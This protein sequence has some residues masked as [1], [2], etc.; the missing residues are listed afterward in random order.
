MSLRNLLFA[1]I[2]ALSL[3]LVVV[4]GK[5]ALDAWK[6][7]EI[8]SEV[9][10]DNALTDL[11]LKSGHFLIEERDRTAAALHTLDGASARG[12]AGLSELR[13]KA[14]AALKQALGGIRAE[15]AFAG[16]E[17]LIGEVETA[18]REARQLRSTVDST[19]SAAID[20]RD[21]RVT[22][23]WN[24]GMT[25]F[26][27][28]VEILR[29]A[30]AREANGADAL[31]G[32]Y[33]ALKHFALVMMDY[34][35]REGSLL[36]GLIH[37]EMPLS[38][39]Q[40]RRLSDYRGRVELAWDALEEA[41]ADGVDPLLE[42][43]VDE[44]RAEF[45][46]V[47]EK[48][49]KA[50]YD[51]GI[52]AQDYPRSA[53]QWIGE[54]ARAMGS[55]HEVLE[56]LIAINEAHAARS[57]SSTMTSL[58]VYLALLAAGLGLSAL[59]FGLVAGRVARPINA[60]TRTMRALAAGDKTVEVPY[61]ERNDEIGEMAKAVR[62]F[63]ENAIERERLQAEQSEAERRAAEER[64]KH[65]EERR[66]AAEDKARRETERLEAE[67]K[68]EQEQRAAEERAEEDKR[69]AV[70]RLADGFEASVMGVVDTVGTASSQLQSTARSM[71]AV[72]EETARQA[73]TVA[74]ASEEASTNVETVSTAAD[75]LS[76]T[77][78]EIGRQVAQSAD[79]T[80]RAVDEAERTNGSVQGLSEAAQKIGEVVGL[81]NDIAEQTNLLALNA[82][83]E[84]ARA[85]EAGKGFAVVA[86]EVKSLATQT[87]KAT[88]EIGSQIAGMQGVTGDVVKAI[89]GI[90]KTIGEVNEIATGIA[91]AVEEQSAA[92]SEI[93]RN[94]QQAAAG[95]QEVSTNIGKVTR[96][97]GE[98]GTAA[99]QVLQSAG[100]LSEQSEA[101]RREVDTFLAQV[102]AA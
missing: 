78:A 79:I 47:F 11:L 88:D 77:I 93:A 61:H 44:A 19:L 53:P 13:S 63:K 92:T 36:A 72:A 80:R 20:D 26:I 50:V 85:G 24:Q 22:K 8:A 40:L 94:V 99:S 66:A 41:A 16:K 69:Q 42:A 89:E 52:T 60:I 27:A 57:A 87:A 45:M 34:A 4:A 71:T 43:A 51:A 31:T 97:A 46:G 67:R 68:A 1:V 32:R 3:L 54:S 30:A 21:H 48:T 55:L 17:Q 12:K 81:I 76:N 64:A 49:R 38:P 35:G 84:A 59:S 9:V 91:T 56:A 90:G 83:I 33:S 29:A 62:V 86:S 73:T 25:A 70:R 74:A 37:Q 28:D 6:G 10:T 95:T 18:L 100:E 23:N 75:E 98:T 7:N 102:N 39:K 15:H 2:G 101:L 58:M 65:D 14:D 5:S 96:G 82:T